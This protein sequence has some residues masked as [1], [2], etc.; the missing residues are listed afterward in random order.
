RL[1]RRLVVTESPNVLLIG[2]G[3]WGEKHL[4]VLRDI[5]ATVW[6]ADV[7]ATRRAW[8][9]QH[10]VAAAGAVDDYHSVLHPADAGRILTPPRRQPCR[11]GRDVPPRRPPVFRREATHGDGRRRPS[12]RHGRARDRTG[13]PGRTYLPVPSRDRGDS[14]RGDG[15]PPGPSAFCHRPVRR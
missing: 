8:A 13:A 1:S 5:G 9:V 4:R 14:D 7:S 12:A 11:D 2:L 6:V 15:A 3:R 10:G